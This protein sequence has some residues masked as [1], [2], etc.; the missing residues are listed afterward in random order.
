MVSVRRDVV[1]CDVFM[2]WHGVFK[3]VL[4]VTN[5]GKLLQ[6]FLQA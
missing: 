3:R 1:W 2:G 5:I 4:K 6:L